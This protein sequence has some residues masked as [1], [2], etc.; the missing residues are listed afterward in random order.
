MRSKLRVKEPF[1]HANDKQGQRKIKKMFRRSMNR[2]N[3]VDRTSFFDKG[4]APPVG[5]NCYNRWAWIF[6]P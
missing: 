4:Y 3:T 6:R 1:V 5:S 2:S